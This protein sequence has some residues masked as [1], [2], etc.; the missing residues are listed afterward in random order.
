MTPPRLVPNKVPRNG[1]QVKYINEQLISAK[2]YVHALGH[3]YLCP[4][5]VA[6]PYR[7][8]KSMQHSSNMAL[9]GLDEELI[10]RISYRPRHLLSS[11]ITIDPSLLALPV[12][13]KAR[14]VDD[15]PSSLGT[16][17]RI[18]LEILHQIFDQIDLRSLLQLSRVAV[19]GR[20][21]VQSLPAYRGLV[22]HA[23]QTLVV[24]RMTKLLQTH[25]V[26]DL[27]AALTSERCATC[28]EY[29][30]YLFLPTCER[31][32]WTCLQLNPARRVV[33]PAKA[34]KTFALSSRQVRKLPVLFSIPGRYGI[35]RDEVLKQYQLVS[36][37][38]ARDLALSI[39]GS[40]EGVVN[41]TESRNYKIPT[42]LQIRYLQGAFT[43]ASGQDPLM[44]PDQGNRGN[45]PFFGLASIP[46]PSLS[47]IPGIPEDGLWCKGCEKTLE[48]YDNRTLP[49]CVITA[50]VPSNC[51]PWRVFFGLASRAYSQSGLLR[52]SQH[53]YGAR[54]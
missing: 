37:S 16:L 38:A 41:L 42:A 43:A 27:F 23:P 45:D 9:Q 52:H 10:A 28:P 36:V 54:Y 46:F 7:V 21:T 33:T 47:G 34:K 53:C 25:T 18:P 20:S 49:A 48:D 29:G 14:R 22:K 1:V 4:T 39:H 6:R 17:D 15:R 51:D 12:S 24:L 40:A 32:C 26:S 35:A 11:M 30:A 5:I 19:R 2:P 44:V 8:N 13:T 50:R 3:N 31:C